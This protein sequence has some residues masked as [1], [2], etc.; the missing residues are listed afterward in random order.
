MSR[1]SGSTCWRRRYGLFRR[2]SSLGLHVKA[3]A[4]QAST[5]EDG[6]LQVLVPKVEEVEMQ[7]HRGTSR[8]QTAP[9]TVRT[10]RKARAPRRGPRP[11]PR[12]RP[13]ATVRRPDI[14]M[15]ACQ[16]G[17]TR[18]ARSPSRC[19]KP[20]PHRWTT[21]QPGTSVTCHRWTER[22]SPR[23]RQP[24]GSRHRPAG[25]RP[26]PVERGGRWCGGA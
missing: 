2:S 23:T 14:T 6:V 15:A 19:T 21:P 9:T 3:D 18:S 7:T 8:G 12:D 11:A 1:T 26:W 20:A 17:E 10:H 16:I 25:R 13:S 5:E 4:I 22:P 24:T